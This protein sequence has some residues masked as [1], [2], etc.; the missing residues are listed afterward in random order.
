M[1]LVFKRPSRDALHLFVLCGRSIA[2]TQMLEMKESLEEEMRHF[3][4]KMMN[5]RVI[6]EHDTKLQAFMKKK[7]QE[8][9]L[10]VQEKDSKKKGKILP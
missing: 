1:A 4:K 6:I 10:S 2:E 5:L 8:I 7:L 9:I 3:S